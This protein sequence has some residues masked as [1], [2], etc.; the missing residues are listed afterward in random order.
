[1]RVR[2]IGL[3][4]ALA[5]VGGAAGFALARMAGED[6]R[7]AAGAAPVAAQS[8]SYPVNEYDVLPDPGIA[9]LAPD[10]PSHVATFA[11]GGL[12][13][14]ASVPIGWRRVALSG[15]NSW[16]FADPDNPSN[17]YLLRIGIDAGDRVS[18][19]VAKTARIAALEDAEQN[20]ALQ[21]VVVESEEEDSFVATYIADGYQRVTMERWLPQHDSDQA[22]AVVAVTGRETDREGMADLLERV[23]SSAEY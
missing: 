21:H 13:M 12:R 11:A 19:R 8:P 16:N 5:L 10:L 22:F 1:M 9:P 18:V 2:W 7:V 23:S 20:G 4:L 15:R 6:P 3:T 17:T 14:T